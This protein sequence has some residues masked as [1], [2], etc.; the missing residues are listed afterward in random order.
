M[1]RISV[2]V[3]NWNTRK[4]LARC[5]EAVFA[6]DQAPEFEVWV[7]DN[8]STDGSVD[9]VRQRFPQA[10]L[11]VNSTNI[12]FARANNQALAQAAGACALLLN[13]DAILPRNGLF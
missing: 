11:I 5:L 12:G 9:E 8:G 1:T 4:L 10:R 6:S 3:V 2:I 7:V 13:S